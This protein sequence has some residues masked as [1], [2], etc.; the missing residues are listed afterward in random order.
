MSVHRRRAAGRRFQRR[1]ARGQLGVTPGRRSRPLAQ[2]M[3]Q[4]ITSNERRVIM[5]DSRQG[6]RRR[7]QRLVAGLGTVAITALGALAALGGAR[8]AW[9]DTIH[10]PS[11]QAPAQ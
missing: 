4:W 11:L 9:G 1:V 10:V 2:S 8:A 5:L 6:A 7:R 3:M